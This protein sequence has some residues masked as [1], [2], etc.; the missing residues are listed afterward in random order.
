MSKTMYSS[1]YK[2]GGEKMANMTNVNIRMDAE[3][4]KQVE[5]LFED[6]G[7]NMTT[8]INMYIKTILRERRIPFEIKALDDD[9]YNPYNLKVLKKSIKS[10]EK[11]KGVTKTMAELEAMENE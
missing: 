2:L 4:K 11:G 7:I 10:L 9:F 1:Y 3:L 6:F 5:E 8:A